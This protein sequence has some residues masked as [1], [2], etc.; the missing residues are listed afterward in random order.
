MNPCKSGRYKTPTG[1]LP[2]RR[3]SACVSVCDVWMREDSQKYLSSSFKG[4]KCSFLHLNSKQKSFPWSHQS[5]APSL[6]GSRWEITWCFHQDICVRNPKVLEMP[7]K[8]NLRYFLIGHQLTLIWWFCFV[9]FATLSLSGSRK[10]AGPYPSYIWVK[11]GTPLHGS[12]AHRRA[13]RYFTQGYLGGALKVFRHLPLRPE[14][15]PF[16]VR[17]RVWTKNSPL[18]GPVLRH[19]AWSDCFL[20][21]LPAPP[22]LPHRPW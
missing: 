14:H 21:N 15:L 12:P 10:N 9:L 17:T 4:Q 1:A 2:W 5:D 7:S 8:D 18:L 22:S 16:F 11:E 6:D 13:L 20:W 3:L 19:R